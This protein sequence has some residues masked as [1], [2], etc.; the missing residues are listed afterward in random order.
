MSPPQPAEET[1]AAELGVED[2][3]AG[4]GVDWAD[5]DGDGRMDLLVSNMYSS[6]GRRVS[7]QPRFQAE[8]DPERRDQ[9]RRHA[10]GNSLFLNRGEDGFL[11]ASEEAAT[12]GG[13]WAWGAVFLD[14][15]NDGRPDIFV[16]NGFVTGERTRD[17]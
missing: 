11:D 9:F 16:P 12:T 1:L 6:A 17:L 2:I 8:A 10:R 3:G 15:Q 14:L 5:V 7:A 4:M 13:R